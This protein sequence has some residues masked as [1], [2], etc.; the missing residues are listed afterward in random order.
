MY[1]TESADIDPD[2][3]HVA[4]M[5]AT[6]AALAL[7]RSR[8]ESNLNEAIA[9]RQQIGMAVGLT[10]AR[11]GIDEERAFAFLV[12]ASNASEM[13]LR[14]LAR[15]VIETATDTYRAAGD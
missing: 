13:K 3:V 2:A 15:E 8:R 10:M 9:T 5:F 7:G 1:S 4:E 12:R 14:D 6:H 11:F